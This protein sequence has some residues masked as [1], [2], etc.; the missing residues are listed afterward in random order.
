MIKKLIGLLALT[1]FVAG[2]ADNGS[3][4]GGYGYS[5]GMGDE[6]LSAPTGFVDPSLLAPAPKFYVGSPYKIESTQYAPA[7]DMYFTQAG[8][9]GIIPVELNGNQT[10]NG[11]TFDVNQMVATHKTLPLPTIVRVTNLENGRAAVLRVNNRGPF[12]N[13]RVMD[14]SPAAARALGITNQSQ[15]QIQVMANESMQVKNATLGGASIAPAPAY[16]APVQ[17]YSASGP[18]TVQ[19]AAFYSEENANTLAQRLGHMGNVRVINEGGMF[20]VRILGQDAAGARRS[21]DTLRSSEGM[22]PGLLKDG[23]WI[24]ADSI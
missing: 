17:E 10:S 9:A 24:N 2:C 7:E 4:V 12:V 5:D 3:Q 18:Y 15:V 20:K 22:S 19:V 13:S 6:S 14:V 23:R 1:A 8:M 11:E 21:I 16:V